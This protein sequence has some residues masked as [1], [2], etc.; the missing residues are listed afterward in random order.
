MKPGLKVAAAGGVLTLALA[1]GASTYSLWNAP[2]NT[3]VGSIVSGNLD[4]TKVD[5]TSWVETSPDV[6]AAGHSID[7]ALFLATPGDT[8]R[9]SQKFSSKL[10]GE[11]MLGKISTRWSAPASLPAGVTASYVLKAPGYA[12]TA[13]AA[14]GTSVNVPNLPVGTTEW[15]IEVTLV[16]AKE[17]ADRFADPAELAK[18]GTIVVDLD[19]VR[20]G[21]GFTS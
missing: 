16:L 15:T 11:N 7:P 21:T 20:T 9:I 12:P 4:L 8:F 5:Q 6:A 19:Q 2:A 13:P 1:A 17:K 18:L 3:A 10:E 14:L